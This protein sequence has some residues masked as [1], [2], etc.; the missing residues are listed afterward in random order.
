MKECGNGEKENVEGYDR[1][2]RMGEKGRFFKDH[3]WRD[4]KIAREEMISKE[5]GRIS[6]ESEKTEKGCEG[7][8]VLNPGGR[9]LMVTKDRGIIRGVEECQKVWVNKSMETIGGNL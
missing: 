2:G 9:K 4:C 7:K 8:K 6:E 5:C 1:C 3:W